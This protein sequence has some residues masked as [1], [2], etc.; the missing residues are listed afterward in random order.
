MGSGPIADIDAVTW[1]RNRF[2]V[3]SSEARSR[4][5][6]GAYHRILKIPVTQDRRVCLQRHQLY[7]RDKYQAEFAP[8]PFVDWLDAASGIPELPPGVFFPG[9]ASY[10]HFLVDGL[11]IFRPADGLPPR[12]YVDEELSDAQIDFVVRFARESGFPAITSVARL[13]EHAYRFEDGSFFCRQPFSHKI[14]WVRSVL[15]LDQPGAAPGTRRL[16]VLRNG[17]RHR[18]LLNQDRIAALVQDRFAFEV[19]DP[20]GMGLW[21][22]ALAFRDAEVVMGGHGAGLANTLFAARP[23]MLVELYHSDRQLFYHSL[24]YALDILHLTIKG[25]RTGDDPERIDN[26][27]FIVDEDAVLREVEKHIGTRP[28]FFASGGVPDSAP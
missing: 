18:R 23:A 22:Q 11:G 24:C 12:L 16:F 21:E 1:A 7:S 5:L 28:G 19:I 25:E 17:A 27:D 4:V 10:W 3:E 8:G 2:V 20:S 15:G 14:R 6:H 26:A 9:A 13:P